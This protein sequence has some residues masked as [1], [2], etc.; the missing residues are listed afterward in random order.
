MGAV[1]YRALVEYALHAS[2]HHDAIAPLPTGE[3][4][5]P[6]RALDELTVKDPAVGDGLSPVLVAA[7][8]E[9]YG[10]LPIATDDLPLHA[11][12]H[13]SACAWQVRLPSDRH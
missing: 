6:Y 9:K 7:V 13:R 8:Y 11:S 2:A 3:D 5:V 10:C 12:A 1:P 4:A